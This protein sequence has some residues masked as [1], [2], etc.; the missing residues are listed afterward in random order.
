MT[1]T[2]PTFNTQTRDYKEELTVQGH[3]LVNKMKEL[4]RQGNVRRIIVK[5]E[6]RT[7]VEFP[8]TV[9]IVG[10]LLAPEL[11]A[12]GAIGA[13]IAECKLEVIRTDQA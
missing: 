9:G 6:G 13:L 2:D 8:L 12:I 4:L 5:H 7:I 10:A 11:A 3:E 1:Q